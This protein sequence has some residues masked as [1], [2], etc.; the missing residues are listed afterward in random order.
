MLTNPFK[1]ISSY[2]SSPMDILS[3]GGVSH[4]QSCAV[5]GDNS[6]VSSEKPGH[7]GRR[8]GPLL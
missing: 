1:I 8:T 6:T 3:V 4:V 5:G 2:T 7:R